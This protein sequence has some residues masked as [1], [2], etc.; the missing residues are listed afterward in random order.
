MHSRCSF[1]DPRSRLQDGLDGIWIGTMKRKKKKKKIEAYLSIHNSVRGVNLSISCI[2][3]H[4]A[5]SLFQVLAEGKERKKQ[6]ER[7]M[8]SVES[9]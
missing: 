6:N 9:K 1:D 3:L 8:E 7:K 2:F 4:S 5:P